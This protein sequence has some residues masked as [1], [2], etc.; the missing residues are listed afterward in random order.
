MRAHVARCFAAEKF[1]QGHNGST[2][3]GANNYLV[4]SYLSLRNAIS[5][6]GLLL[7]VVLALGKSRQPLRDRDLLDVVLVASDSLT[8]K[9]SLYGS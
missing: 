8:Y 6:I 2:K 5:V 1:S 4:I 3:L 7:P 9:E